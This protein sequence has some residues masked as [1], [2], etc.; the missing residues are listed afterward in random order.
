MHVSQEEQYIDET[1]FTKIVKTSRGP[2]LLIGYHVIH[3]D[4]DDNEFWANVISKAMR[5]GRHETQDD[6]CE[7]SVGS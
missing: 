6:S 5:R 4:S 1:A 2:A 3:L 7:V